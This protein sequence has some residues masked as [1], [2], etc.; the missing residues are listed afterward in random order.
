MLKALPYQAAGLGRWMELLSRGEMLYGHVG[1]LPETMELEPLQAD[2]KSLVLVPIFVDERWWGNI[3]FDEC[4]HE[5][6]FSALERD[7]LKAAADTLGAAI[8]RARAGQASARLAAIVES[9]D[10]AIIGM[11]L[12][13]VITTWNPGAE[14]LFGYSAE[15]AIGQ[16]MAMLLPPEGLARMPEGLANLRS[17]MRLEPY[18]AKRI[19]K[20]G[21]EIAVSVS[22]SPIRDAQGNLFG[23]SSIY[24]DITAQKRAETALRRS[25][26]SYQDLVHTIDGIVWEADAA[27]VRFSFV[28]DQ[29]ER[30]LGYPTAR[31]IEEPTFWQDHMHPDDRDWGTSFCATAT[32][33]KRDHEFEY[34]MIAA[35]GRVVWLRDIVTV[36]VEDDRPVKLRGVMVDITERKQTEQDLLRRDAILEAVRF[37]GERF[38]A[39]GTTWEE[40]VPQVLARLGQAAAVSRVYVFERYVESDGTQWATQRFE[41][42]APGIVAQIDDARLGAFPLETP[43][44]RI[45]ADALRRG[46]L[47]HGRVRELPGIERVPVEA[48]GPHSLVLVPIFVDG[49]WWGVIGFDECAYERDFSPMERDALKAAADTLG[50]AIGR[51][52]ANLEIKRERDFSSTVLDTVGALVAVLDRQGR[53]VRFNRACEQLTGYAADE[54]VGQTYWELFLVPEEMDEVREMMADVAAGH[55]PHAHENIWVMRDGTHRLIAWNNTAI[56]DEGGEPTFLIKTGID[57][58][59]RRRAEE[60]RRESQ[61]RLATLLSN[62]P[63]MAY[64]HRNEPNRTMEFVSDGGL[65]LTGYPPSDLIG[66]DG[67]TYADLVHPDERAGIWR[68]MQTAIAADEPFRLTYRITTAG[69]AEKWVMEQGRGVRG[70]A[71]EH[72]AIEGIIT[73]VTDRVQARQLLEQRVATLTKLASSLTIDQPMETTLNSLATSL[74]DASGAAACV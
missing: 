5:R 41:W 14:R 17:G 32:A 19:R 20:D 22:F 4:A 16:S 9:S 62:L 6:D 13:G 27:T 26:Q 67:L 54:V 40:S 70:S 7:A 50:A 30:L 45:W 48:G 58:T 11:A 35:D 37:A 23:T 12:D 18:E 1:E 24:R 72:L 51:D 38:L 33:E 15:E 64:R 2:F 43:V 25:R 3:G 47:L 71:G 49:L 63:G 39:S 68:D 10:D 53:I 60:A 56:L 73:D 21:S 36:V 65:E 44:F 66:S 29:A 42:T 61:R 31:W 8:G 74:A 52:R 69:G 57:I 55:F 59:E 46:E 34:R 28:S